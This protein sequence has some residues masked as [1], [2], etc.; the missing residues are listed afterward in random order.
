MSQLFNSN[1]YLDTDYCL[2]ASDGSSTLFSELP[3]FL[4]V[5]LTTDGTVTKKFRVVFLG[6]GGC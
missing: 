1:G 3:A 5:L 2:T 6:V 4:R